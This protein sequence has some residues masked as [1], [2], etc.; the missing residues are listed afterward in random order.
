MKINIGIATRVSFVI[1]PKILLG[2][3]Y[4]SVKSKLL[5]RLQ[6]KANKI[7]TPERVKAT[8]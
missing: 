4:R 5:L 6:A 3:A 7:E 8:G 1:S 2:R